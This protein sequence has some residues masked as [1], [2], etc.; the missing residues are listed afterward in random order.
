MSKITSN[1]IVVLRDIPTSDFEYNQTDLISD[2][3]SNTWQSERSPAEKAADSQVG[4]KA[5]KAIGLYFGQGFKDNRNPLISF[6][7]EFREDDF[8][9]H[10]SL[11]FIFASS[12]DKLSWAKQK[13]V[14]HFKAQGSKFHKIKPD[15][16]NELAVE[17]VRIC[18]IKA[19]RVRKDRKQNNMVN[20]NALLSDDFLTYPRFV[21]SNE[22][23]EEPIQEANDYIS[24]V[25]TKYHKSE[26]EILET[27]KRNVPHWLFRVYIDETSDDK[28]DAYII[29]GLKG[30]D[31][32]EGNTFNIKL[33]PSNKS[34]K[35]IYI[36]KSLKAGV[37]MAEFRKMYSV[38]F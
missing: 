22:N 28:F 4:K 5:E 7:D 32:F 8:L 13:I 24:Y 11:D 10:N 1:D 38:L 18:E 25:S 14:S 37:P 17:Q 36:A 34:S 19:T 30:K 27:E 26:S 3:T 12:E 33:M 15:V 2:H 31:F 9:C 6:Y 20:L 21:R 23:L 16:A 29:G 35:A